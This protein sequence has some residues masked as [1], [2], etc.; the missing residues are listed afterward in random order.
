MDDVLN[1]HGQLQSQDC[2]TIIPMVQAKL[3]LWQ[4]LLRASSGVLNPLKYSST[5][6]TWQFDKLGNAVLT[7]IG[8]SQALKITATD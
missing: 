3:T 1:I 4:G 6:V 5:P 8:P 7:R 2:S